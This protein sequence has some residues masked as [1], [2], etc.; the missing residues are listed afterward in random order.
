[1][2]IALIHDWLVNYA[3]SE[4]V[5]EQ[6]LHCYPE[7]DVF[8]VVDFIP[9]HD[10]DWLLN[11][12]V[13]TTFIQKLPFAK[14]KY[15]AYLPLMPLAIEQLDLSEYDLIISSSHAVAK[16]VITGPD[17]T[18]ICYIHS[19]MRYAW[20]LQSQYLK[21][22]NL[23]RGF[24]SAL[25]R[26][27]LHRLRTW[28]VISA[29]RVDYFIANS[30]YI[31]RRIRKCYRRDAVVIHPPVDVD[32]FS[33][34][35][36]K[37]DFYFVCSRMVPY[38]R[39]DLIVEAFNEMPDKK[40]IVIGNGPDFQKVKKKSGK[41]ITLL[42]YQPKEVI[43]DYLQKAAAFVFA[44]VEDFGIAPVEAM[45]CGTPVI[46]LGKGGITDS[47]RPISETKPTGIFYHSQDK[48]SLLNA[49][50]DFER[51][52]KFISPEFCQ[53]QANMFSQLNFRLKFSQYVDNLIS[54]KHNDDH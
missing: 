37:E 9:D 25:T 28:D 8:S 6:I 20:D 54:K 29:N 18:H 2:K 48:E 46:A 44:A 45:A 34:S 13:Q 41:N 42:G 15:R 16:G 12:K 30:H 49:V 23:Q 10:R 39:I 43:R 27:L 33:L 35:T 26:Y 40:L 21:E 38:K 22:S 7:A 52:K 19:P 3:G 24:K 53:Q 50:S 36:Q 4:Q 14:K 1:M 32:Y 51:N 11:K 5:L 31:A 47:V 17:Q